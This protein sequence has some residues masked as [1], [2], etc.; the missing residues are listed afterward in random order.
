MPTKK[1]EATEVTEKNQISDVTLELIKRKEAELEKWNK[2][3]K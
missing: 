2:G 1:T 3:G